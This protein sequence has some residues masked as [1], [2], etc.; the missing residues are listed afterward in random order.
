MSNGF[1]QI[2]FAD[3]TPAFE[4]WRRAGMSINILSSG[5]SLA[6]QLL[7]AHTESGDLSQ[8]IDNCFDTMVGSILF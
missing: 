7:F 2:A 1:L 8:F 5:S 4:R 3:V 6:Q